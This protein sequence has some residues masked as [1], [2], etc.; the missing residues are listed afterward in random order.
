MRGKIILSEE[1]TREIKRMLDSGHPY[2]EIS[3]QFGVST[4]WIKYSFGSRRKRRLHCIRTIKY[5]NIAE[6]MYEN[7]VSREDISIWIGLSQAH[8][9]RI[10][11]G[12][13]PP[14]FEFILKILEKTGM[15]FEEAFSERTKT[16]RDLCHAK[17]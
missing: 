17:N 8:T 3:N 1:V 4:S 14:T 15:E 6:W 13:I 11:T 16:G 7:E 5:P 12:K 9:N 2:R 10:L